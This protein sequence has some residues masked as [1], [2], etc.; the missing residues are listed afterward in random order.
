[1]AHHHIPELPLRWIPPPPGP[2]SDCPR[3]S[4]LPSRLRSRLARSRDLDDTARKLLAAI[5]V[6]LGAA[7]RA[8]KHAVERNTD[9]TRS[10]LVLREGLSARAVIMHPVPEAHEETGSLISRSAWTWLQ[11]RLSPCLVDPAIGAVAGLPQGSHAPTEAPAAPRVSDATARFLDAQQG[12]HLLVLPLLDDQ[13]VLR[14]AIS[15]ALRNL[16]CAGAGFRGLTAWADGWMAALTEATPLLLRH[17]PPAAEAVDA[18]ALLPVIGDS[19]RPIF[20]T[21]HRV[22]R[23]RTTVLLQ[24]EP[25][26]GKSRLAR[27]LH[28]MSSRSAGPFV[29]AHLHTYTEDLLPGALFGWKK[30]AHSGATHDHPGLLGEAEGGTLFLDEVDR[31]PLSTQDRLLHL[32]ES[33]VYR[34]LS[35]PEQ[36][37]NVRIL[38]GTNRDLEALAEAGSFRRD[39][40]D[41][42]A[43]V[44]ITLPPLRQR[45]DE[46][47]AWARFMV[48][49]AARDDGFTGSV[50]FG[51]GALERL[52]DH[53]WPRNLRGLQRCVRRA[54][55]L[56]ADSA[57][58]RDTVTI[59]VTAI[60]HALTLGFVGKS[61]AAPPTPEHPSSATAPPALHEAIQQVAQAWLAENASREAPLPF[62]WGESVGAAIV[63]EAVKQAGNRAEGLR[64]LGLERWVRGG[65]S[66]KITD[67][68]TRA[69][70]ELLTALQS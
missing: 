41:R 3:L 69:W 49:D 21:L 44:A 1:M 40:L 57:D 8:S 13:S 42:I 50:S 56:V 2:P 4:M 59:P 68:A 62:D 58:P 61:A 11:A 53:S 5:E 55:M 23:S 7:L 19:T 9:V 70:T 30:G 33:R 54:W 52:A 65:N 6:D 35:G 60:D 28:A 47:P 24:G 31:M 29:S 48:R 51:P 63:H 12:T 16:A 14:G 18:D 46:I 38:V 37:A 32:L 27:W 26:V 36:R 34:P 22:A 43:D 20:T 45:R 17:H 64:G 15:I 10:S 66:K 39:L 67:R 25:G